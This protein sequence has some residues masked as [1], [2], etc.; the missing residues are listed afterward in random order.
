[1][2]L[3]KNE[4]EEDEE[5]YYFYDTEDPKHN[6]HNEILYSKNL[7]L[8]ILEEQHMKSF[9]NLHLYI[10]Y[11]LKYED[12]WD[13]ESIIKKIKVLKKDLTKNNDFVMA[14]IVHFYSKS[15]IKKLLM[16]L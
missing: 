9:S 11:C 4:L 2:I 6:S 5:Y 12:T 16:L 7:I 10:K 14:R 13:Y 8:H 3:N 15:E 1:M